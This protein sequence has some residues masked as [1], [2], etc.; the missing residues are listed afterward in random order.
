MKYEICYI[1]TA[2][3]R[4]YFN[5]QRIHQCLIKKLNSWIEVYIIVPL[6]H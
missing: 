2:R 6:T 1:G 3:R 5:E 4:L